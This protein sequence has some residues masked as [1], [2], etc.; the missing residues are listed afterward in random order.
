MCTCVYRQNEF[1][2]F[3]T[4]LIGRCIH[5]MCRVKRKKK[6]YKKVCILRESVVVCMEGLR[7]VLNRIFAKKKCLL[8]EMGRF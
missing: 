3:G 6:L 7:I 1:K 8:R 5:K 2:Q 4:N